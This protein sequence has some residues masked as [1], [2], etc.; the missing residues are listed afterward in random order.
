MQELYQILGS[1]LGEDYDSHIAPG[2][3]D[4]LALLEAMPMDIIVSDL[5]M[6]EMNGREFLSRVVA[7]F[8]ETI[9][10]VVSGF[11]DQL[12]V[13]QCLMFGH[14][15]FQKPFLL[16][17]FAGTLKRICQLK[18]LIGNEKIKRVVCELGALPT[19]PDTYFRLTEVLNSPDSTIED[20]T[21]IV[22][23]DPGLTVKVLQIV[24]SAEFGVARRITTPAEAV[25]LIGAEILRAL[26]LSVQAFKFYE[27]KPPKSISVT[28][29]WSHSLRTAVA[30][31]RLA[32]Y[33]KLTI[34]QS[35]A[36][37]VS[38]LLHDIGKLVLAANVDSDYDIAIKRSREE[39]LPLGIIEQVIFGATHAQIGAFLLG[40]WGLP[41]EVVEAV[42][43]HHSLGTLTAKGF[44][45]ST[46]VHVAQCLEPATNRFANLDHEYL[47][48]IG[49]DQNV[50]VW[51]QLLTT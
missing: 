8:P 41:D 29:L 42:E 17:N 16:E 34:E 27:T 24:N 30:A 28:Q 1:F 50:N 18:H 33:E 40:L 9:R 21:A 7:K 37:F 36:A 47:K 45:V 48:Q 13:A 2:G 6:P 11:A 38:G 20:I 51:Q 35:E 22:L 39:G 26:M 23:E 5:A 43:V 49:V 25:Q 12:T 44:S 14:R 31:K 15:Y 32:R 4:A 10:I 19:P 3:A 46:A